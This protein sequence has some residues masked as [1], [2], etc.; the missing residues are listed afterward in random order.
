MGFGVWIRASCK[1]QANS[2]G[3]VPANGF[4]QRRLT[5]IAFRVR[6]RARIQKSSNHG[7]GSGNVIWIQNG[8]EVR[9]EARIKAVINRFVQR[10]DAVDVPSIDICA[11][12]KQ[13]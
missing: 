10:R 1:Q 13:H 9:R 11:D 3:V 12:R 5:V 7:A 8:G 2:F 4:M 6:I